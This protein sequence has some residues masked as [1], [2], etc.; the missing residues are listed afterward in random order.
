[1]V[2]GRHRETKAVI[3][4]GAIY[5]NVAVEVS[6]LR[7]GQELFAVVKANAYG[8]GLLPV[9]RVAKDAGA[10]GFCVA[11]IDEGLA[12]REAGF[13][14]P[15]LILGVNNPLEAVIMAQNDL[16]VSVGDVSFL[17]SAAPLLR[18]SQLKLKVHLALDTGMGRIGFRCSNDLRQALGRLDRYV[19]EFEFAGLFTHF[20]S[21]DSK[22]TY[23]FEQQLNNLNEMLKI[24][25]TLPR[26]VHCANT[27]TAMWH[28]GSVGNVVRYGIGMYGLN[29][30]GTELTE[31]KKLRPAL[32]LVSQLIAVKQV[33]KGATIGYGETYLASSDEWIG[34]IP[35]GYADGWSRSLQGF[36]V[37]VDGQYCEIVGRVCMDQI[38]VR[39]PHQFKVG[40]KVT[41]IGTNG[42]NTI[43][44]QQVAD[45]VHTIHYE[46]ISA[47]TE[48]VQRV[49]VWNE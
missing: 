23:Y 19:E 9:A 40:T 20:A 1:M 29:P 6:R 30:S 15:I 21:A 49:Y 24:V 2:V 41:L 42:K 18:Q 48:R 28:S 44:A 17:D 33:Q 38:M 45:Y 32:E 3:D 5:H 43:T 34:T 37:L 27:A 31:P 4:L 36:S 14:E 25:P 16:S 47:L 12:L 11:L 8:H 22:E 13:T 46:V 10:S 35:I 26:Y 39:L 7:K